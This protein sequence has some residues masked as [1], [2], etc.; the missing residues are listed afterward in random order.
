MNKLVKWVSGLLAVVLF[1]ALGMLFAEKETIKNDLIRLH[2]VAASDSTRDQAHKLAVR[3]ALVN[4]MEGFMTGA[5]N[6]DQAQAWLQEHLE[7][8]EGVANETLRKIGSLDTAKVSLCWEEFPQRDYETFSLPSGLYKALRVTI[9][10]GQGQNWWCVVFPTLC[11]NATAQGVTEVAAGAGFTD[12]LSHTL[13]RDSGYEISFFLLDCIG[14]LE[15]FF[16]FG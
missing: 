1:L 12:H 11:L 9:G 14:K 7:E 2:V 16:H 6:V 4:A 10:Q 8:L 15:N 13:T 5:V 3:D